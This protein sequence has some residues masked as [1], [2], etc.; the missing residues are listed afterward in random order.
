MP[1]GWHF[2]RPTGTLLPQKRAIIAQKQPKWGTD[3]SKE[4]LGAMILELHP[5]HRAHPLQSLFWEEANP[6]R[7]LVA[8]PISLHRRSASIMLDVVEGGLSME[9]WD[10][11]S[12]RSFTR[13]WP[14]GRITAGS[15][16]LFHLTAVMSRTRRS[17]RFLFPGLSICFG[18]KRSHY[19]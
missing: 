14:E 18:I 2:C 8:V 3:R 11:L 13:G 17:T 4:R 5:L 16:D 10:L 19:A 12:Q 1:R 7:P 6:S 15:Q 9:R